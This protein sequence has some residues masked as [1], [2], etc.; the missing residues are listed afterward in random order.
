MRIKVISVQLRK[1]R[2]LKSVC[3]QILVVIPALRKR[4]HKPLVV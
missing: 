3:K 4:H 2:K 1:L